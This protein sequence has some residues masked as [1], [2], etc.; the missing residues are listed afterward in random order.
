[1]GHL[2]LQHIQDSDPGTRR[3]VYSIWLRA[4]TSERADHHQKQ[5]Q[6]KQTHIIAPSCFSTQDVDNDVFHH[7]QETLAECER[8]GGFEKNAEDYSWQG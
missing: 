3:Q 4:R 7:G 8:K 6:A 5:H 2:R 1:M